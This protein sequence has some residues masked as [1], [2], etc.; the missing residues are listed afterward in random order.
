MTAF[1]GTAVKFRKVLRFTGPFPRVCQ[2]GRTFFLASFWGGV[3]PRGR[4]V[5]RTPEWFRQS[6]PFALIISIPTWLPSSTT[7]V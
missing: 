1:Q 5:P 4:G 6:R 7:S 3:E 2:L